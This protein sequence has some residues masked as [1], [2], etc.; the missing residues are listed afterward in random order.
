MARIPDPNH[1]FLSKVDG[2]RQTRPYFS[3]IFSFGF[4]IACAGTEFFFALRT[5]F[6]DVRAHTHIHTNTQYRTIPS[7]IAM[8]HFTEVFMEV[9][10]THH[11]FPHVHHPSPLS[12][13]PRNDC[14]L[15]CSPS[16]AAAG[17]PAVPRASG[18][19]K[20]GYLNMD[21]RRPGA[22]EAVRG[23]VGC[24]NCGSG[25]HTAKMCPEP[26]FCTLCKNKVRPPRCA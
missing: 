18:E 26:L 24:F 17:D 25:E 19:A 2:F 15:S 16:P 7:P 12:P 3:T 1:F 13:G 23:R 8:C 22:E 21:R 10:T 9:Y 20:A 5:A 6:V 4:F 14:S 11:P